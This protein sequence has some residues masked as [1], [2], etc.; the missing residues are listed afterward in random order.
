MA[1]VKTMMMTRW[2]NSYTKKNKVDTMPEEY[3]STT[4]VASYL[5]ITPGALHNWCKKPPTGFPGSD[6]EI[7]GVDKST[8]ARGWHPD[9]LK[10]LRRWYVGFYRLPGDVA[11]HR[12]NAIDRAMSDSE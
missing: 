9:S 8:T 1:I 10:G 7:I 11:T 2:D 12:W 5:G 6:I 4:Y 3:F